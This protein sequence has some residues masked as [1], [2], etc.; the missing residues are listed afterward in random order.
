MKNLW[1]ISCFVLVL[2]SCSIWICKKPQ[3][4]NTVNQRI[5]SGFFDT[6]NV[7]KFKVKINYN[8]IDL[9]GILIYKK[10]ND[11]TLAGSFINEFGINGFDFTISDSHAKLGY[12]FESLDKGYIRRTLETD[13]H[14]L[15]ARPILQTICSINDTSA[16]VANINRS[17]HYVY[18]FETEQKIVRADMYK[19]MSKIANLRQYSDENSGIIL[20]MVHTKGSM[21]YELDEINN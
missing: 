19:R 2:T 9:S 20:R 21:S 1:F 10:I 17:L 3:T 7:R 16:W 6:L 18:Y 8:T 14:F 4:E 13:L 15:F 11:S 12:L 5:L